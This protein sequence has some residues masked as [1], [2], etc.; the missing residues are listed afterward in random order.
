MNEHNN[1]YFF[2]ELFFTFM[3]IG[4][5]SFGGGYAMLSLI[6]HTCVEQKQWITDEEM[7]EISIIAESTPG[8]IAVNMATYVGYKNGGIPGS[9]ISTLGFILPSGI[10]I[11]ILSTS[12]ISLLNVPAVIKAFSG[13]KSAA[14]ILIFDAAVTMFAKL[15][16]DYFSISIFIFAFI[17]MFIINLFH[18]KISSIE[19]MI[20]SSALSLLYWKLNDKNHKGG[21]GA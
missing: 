11:Y 13:I 5:V 17:F 12:L 16:K 7:T 8:P 18:F 21:A 1:K 15:T 3:K 19:L 10:L 14:A 4:A 2:I 9:L 6:H 20:L